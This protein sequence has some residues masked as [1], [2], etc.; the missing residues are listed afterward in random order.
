MIPSREMI[1]EIVYLIGFFGFPYAIYYNGVSLFFHYFCYDFPMLEFSQV[2]KSFAGKTVI[3]EVSFQ[4]KPGEMLNIVSA[5]GSGKTVLARM[6]AGL[7]RQTSGDIS[8]DTYDMV[9]EPEAVKQRLGYLPQEIIFPA[10][11]KTIREFLTMYAG[12]Y[13]KPPLAAWGSHDLDAPCAGLSPDQKKKLLFAAI[14]AVN[15][16]AVILDEPPAG[17]DGLEEYLK[18][19]GSALIFSREPLT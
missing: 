8:L 13:R 19:G 15:P 2:S 5:A 6:A 18:S 7:L 1:V 16:K 3:S 12:W 14:L 11:A 10:G 17:L 4:V 9:L